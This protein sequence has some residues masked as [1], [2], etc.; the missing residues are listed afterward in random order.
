MLF[1]RKHVIKKSLF[2]FIIFTI[3][4]FSSCKNLQP[5][6][7]DVI[8]LDKTISFSL[9]GKDTIIYIDEQAYIPTKALH[10]Y[11]RHKFLGENPITLLDYD[12]EKKEIIRLSPDEQKKLSKRFFDKY[13][14]VESILTKERLEYIISLKERPLNWKEREVVEIKKIKLKKGLK[15]RSDLVLIGNRI[16]RPAYTKNK[17]YAFIYST[18]SVNTKNESISI[19]IYKKI[20]GKWV[21][22]DEIK[23]V[24]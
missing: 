3:I 16:S 19:F 8:L 9:K 20:K 14:R 18:L 6:S 15:S 11:Y 21:L 13:K 5:K 10:N 1:Q 24:L 7:D 4:A 17:N 23:N 2:Y 12:S 22:I